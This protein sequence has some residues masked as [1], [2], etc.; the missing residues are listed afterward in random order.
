MSILAHQKPTLGIMHL[1]RCSTATM[2]GHTN[3]LCSCLEAGKTYFRA[4]HTPINTQR[5][6]YLGLAAG[7]HWG[8]RSCSARHWQPCQHSVLSGR[9]VHCRSGRFPHG[10]CPSDYSPP[11]PWMSMCYMGAR[12]E[13]RKMLINCHITVSHMLL[14]CPLVSW[15]VMSCPSFPTCPFLHPSSEFFALLYGPFPWI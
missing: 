3:T 4:V 1:K 2:G 6:S 8:V 11:G 5:F 7:K 10:R 15:F 9:R 12:R 13:E 14:L